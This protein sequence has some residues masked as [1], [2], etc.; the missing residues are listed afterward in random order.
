MSG[1]LKA[2]LTSELAPVPRTLLTVY[3]EVSSSGKVFSISS[4]LMKTKIFLLTL[5]KEITP[6]FSK[7]HVEFFP[8]WWSLTQV[9]ERRKVIKPGRFEVP[10]SRKLVGRWC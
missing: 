4:L 1:I 6:L 2:S 5:A 8:T 3:L 7:G 10:Y 9:P